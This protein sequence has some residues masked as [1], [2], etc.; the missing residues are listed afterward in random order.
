MPDAHIVLGCRIDICRAIARQDWGWVPS[1]WNPNPVRQVKAMLNGDNEPVVF[2]SNANNL[3]GL[4]PETKV[5][6]GYEWL[7][8][9]G[10]DPR[11][12]LRA[13]IARGGKVLQFNNGTF[14]EVKSL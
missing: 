1:T 10:W 7:F 13:H 12:I 9:W 5:Y 4:S 3:R 8:A 2:T 14:E 6:L 11:E